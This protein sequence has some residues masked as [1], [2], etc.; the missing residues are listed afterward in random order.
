[1]EFETDPGTRVSATGYTV[2]KPGNAPNRYHELNHYQ[3]L[4]ISVVGDTCAQ[5]QLLPN[6]A[7][8]R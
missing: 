3:F 6:T 4:G 7:S 8:I 2:P 5:R 1:M